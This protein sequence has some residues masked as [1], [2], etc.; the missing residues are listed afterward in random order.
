MKFDLAFPAMPSGFHNLLS[1]SFPTP[2][3][4]GSESRDLCTTVG[5]YHL[6]LTVV[7]L[8]VL[9]KKTTSVEKLSKKHDP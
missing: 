2:L 6:R 1:W 5:L 9:A 7:F 3:S 4:P 8:G